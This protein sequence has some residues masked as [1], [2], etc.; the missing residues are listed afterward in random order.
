MW[1]IF[2]GTTLHKLKIVE[3][4]NGDLSTVEKEF[5]IAQD[6]LSLANKM[7]EWKAYVLVVWLRAPLQ[8]K[9]IFFHCHKPSRALKLQTKKCALIESQAHSSKFWEYYP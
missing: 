6:E 7:P 2:H 4:A 3:N 9:G 8:R 5:D 1:L